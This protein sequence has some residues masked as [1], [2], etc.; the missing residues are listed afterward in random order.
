MV[1]RGQLLR[2]PEAL[3]AEQAAGFPAVALTAWWAL[4]ELAHPR[5]G[6]N[7]LVH[8]AA[9]GVGSMLVQLAKV[10]GCRV[11]GVVGAPHKVEPVRQ[12][13]ADAVI[14]K[15]REPLWATAEKL[16]PQGFDVVLDANGVSTLGGSYRHLAPAGKLVVQLF[17]FDDVAKAHQAIEGGQTVG[18]LVLS[19]E[20]GSRAAATRPASAR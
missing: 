13:G 17:A 10:A 4:F 15:S 19:L 16:A 7:V 3:T 9:G 8:S 6:S 1:P 12:L 2:R 5:R 18:K 11:V 20:G 14:D